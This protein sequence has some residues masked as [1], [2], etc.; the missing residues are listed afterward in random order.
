MRENERDIGRKR[1]EMGERKIYAEG[2][3]VRGLKRRGGEV[4]KLVPNARTTFATCSEWG[5]LVTDA[6]NE[7]DLGYDLSNDRTYK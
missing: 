6:H 2:T 3:C 4:V 5:P 7:A 1:R